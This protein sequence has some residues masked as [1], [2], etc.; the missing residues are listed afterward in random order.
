MTTIYLETLIAAPKNVCF[1]L[2]RNIDF[3]MTSMKG[4]GEQAIDGRTSGLIEKG[5]FVTWEATHFLVR[6][7]LSSRITEMVK[8]DYFVDEMIEGIFKSIWH[9]HSFIQ[10]DEK[11]L[12]RDEFRYKVPFGFIGKIVDAILLKKY[13]KHLL[14]KRNLALKEAAESNS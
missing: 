5:E 8:P 2:S 9:K 10:F 7:R 12:M 13:M 3:H 11:T 6:Q 4:S 14:V 1:D